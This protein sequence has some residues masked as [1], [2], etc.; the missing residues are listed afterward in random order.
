MRILRQAESVPQTQYLPWIQLHPKCILMCAMINRPL[1]WGHTAGMVMNP[2]VLAGCRASRGFA[3]LQKVVCPAVSSL[4][5]G[6]VAELK[7]VV[8]TTSFMTK[9]HA[10]GCQWTRPFQGRLRLVLVQDDMGEPAERRAVNLLR[11]G[12]ALVGDPFRSRSSRW[13]REASPE[14]VSITLT[15][16]EFLPHGFVST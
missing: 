14:G 4:Q 15:S 7:L 8:M 12:A 9:L 1:T 6:A 10:G 5:Q 3:Y 2:S 16:W 13:N 11:S